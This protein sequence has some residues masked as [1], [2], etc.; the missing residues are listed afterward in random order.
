MKTT[1]ILTGLI[2]TLLSS[3]ALALSPSSS[4][5]NDMSGALTDLTLAAANHG[6]QLVK[7]QPMDNALV[8]RGYAD[9]G[10]RVAFIGKAEQVEQAVATDP[11]LLS[12]LPMRIVMV[13]EGDSVRISADDLNDWKRQLPGSGDVLDGWSQDIN[14]IVADYARQ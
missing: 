5:P 6:Y 14:A 2:M 8:K 13:R 12:L 11:A 10:V 9:P 7:V 3:T 4:K 1:K